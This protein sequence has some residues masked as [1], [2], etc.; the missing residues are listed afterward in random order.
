MVGESCVGGLIGWGYGTVENC[1]VAAGNVEGDSATGGLVGLLE[2]S[3]SVTESCNKADVSGTSYTGGLVGINHG[4]TQNS[5]G[6][7]G[8][9]Q[10]TAVT[11]GFIGLSDNLVKNCYASMS[12]ANTG[13]IGGGFIGKKSGT[14]TNCYWDSGKT[15]LG[16]VGSGD[17]YGIEEGGTAAFTSFDPSDGGVREI[18][19][20]W[21]F[22]DIWA[23]LSGKNTGYPYLLIERNLSIDF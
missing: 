2:S 14:A 6:H 18:F 12:T 16:A 11:G 7:G 10:G 9:V 17:T 4:E 5:Y 8:E 13:S 20:G 1:S 3:G 22:S 15:A 23:I 21:D 19:L